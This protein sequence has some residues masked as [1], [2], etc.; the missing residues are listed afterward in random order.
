MVLPPLRVLTEGP[1][2]QQ[3]RTLENNPRQPIWSNEH[4]SH[5]KSMYNLKH[6]T[7]E[8]PKGR[9]DVPFHSKTAFTFFVPD[10]L[11]RGKPQAKEVN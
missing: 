3:G 9:S 11:Q 1:H 6:R 5:P 10:S 2:T 7:A 8:G 4:F